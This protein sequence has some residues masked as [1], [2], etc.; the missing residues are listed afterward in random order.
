MII[1]DNDDD[2]PKNYHYIIVSLY[3]YIIISLCHSIDN[4]DD[5]YYLL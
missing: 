2:Y 4:D 5:N 3:H 1:D